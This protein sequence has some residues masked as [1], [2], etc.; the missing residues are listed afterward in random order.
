[1]A[2][3]A[4][5]QTVIGDIVWI[6]EQHDRHFLTDANAF[7]DHEDTLET[8]I[9]GKSFKF[10][11]QI[12]NATTQ[13]RRGL[14]SVMAV[15]RSML[16]PALL[17][18][19]A[20]LNFPETTSIG[21]LNRLRK[22]F[23]DNGLT[24]PSRQFSFGSVTAET[25]NTGDGTINRLTVDENNDTIEN[26]WAETVTAECTRDEHSGGVEHQEGFQFRG[27]APGEDFLDLQGSGETKLINCL[28]AADSLE[29]L[30]NPSFS[31]DTAGAL[32][33]A[34]AGWTI[35][36]GTAANFTVN[37]DT[38]ASELGSV[39]RGFEGDT[40]PKSLQFETNAAISQNFN[41]RRIELFPAVPMYLQ[42]AYWVDGTGGANTGTLTLTLGSQTNTAT[43]TTATTGWN[44]LRMN[45]G[46][47]NWF[48]TFNQEDP[49]VGI[50]LT[51]GDGA[52]WVDDV[53]FGRYVDFNG[54]WYAPVGG[55]T[56]FLREDTFTMA[57]T[58]GIRT[59]GT[60]G[61]IQH[62]LWRLYDFYL[63]AVSTTPSWADP[64]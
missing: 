9:G 60:Q 30:Q 34:P 4:Q 13:F 53:V 12:L 8:D 55:A 40:T 33:A 21:V 17:E 62:W 14:N 51:G 2:T 11:D 15:G 10:G 32:T 24:I 43:I 27:E 59:S 35:D 49:K 20:V 16:D 57:H 54:I 39:Y 50:A 41:N 63:P 7:D 3:E 37:T 46:Q 64:T 45:I 47:K 58:N 19:G 42:I 29:F 36:T 44:I 26:T 5:V 48:K 6:L 18:Y 56:P 22:Y 28:S 25:A 38:T 23:Q 52:V 1:M 31:D 61:L